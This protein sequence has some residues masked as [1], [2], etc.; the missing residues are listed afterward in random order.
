MTKPHKKKLEDNVYGRYQSREFEAFR[1]IPELWNC[2]ATLTAQWFTTKPFHGGSG[3]KSVKCGEPFL[4]IIDRY[5][6]QGKVKV[7]HAMLMTLFVGVRT[8]VSV[9]LFDGTLVKHRQSS[10]LQPRH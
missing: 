3:T 6:P 10:G 8:S 2:D 9:L 7:P 1:V 5:A 4:H